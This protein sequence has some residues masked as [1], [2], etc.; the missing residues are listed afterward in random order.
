MCTHAGWIKAVEWEKNEIRKIK[1]K[2]YLFSPIIIYTSTQHLS[3]HFCEF[4]FT[5][6]L[7]F[8]YHLSVI[9]NNT[10]R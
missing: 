5:L 4:K 2:I 3:Q 7:V 1:S 8:L 6:V 10:L 9:N